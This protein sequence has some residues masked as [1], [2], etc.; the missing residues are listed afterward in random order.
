[1]PQGKKKKKLWEVNFLH[2]TEIFYK[3]GSLIFFKK[4][5]VFLLLEGG[6]HS[7]NISKHLCNWWLK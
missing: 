4:H 7:V 6:D 3:W 2:D 5:V 1:M